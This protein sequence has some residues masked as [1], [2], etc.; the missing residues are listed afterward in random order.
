[1]V[2]LGLPPAR[3]RD[4]CLYGPYHPY[5][6]HNEAQALHV[7]GGKSDNSEITVWIKGD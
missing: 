2:F 4:G 6:F 3:I 7:L 5:A 1:M